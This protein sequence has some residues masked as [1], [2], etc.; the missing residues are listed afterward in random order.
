MR[1]NR[2]LYLLIVVMIVA[3]DQGSKSLA[4]LFL[5]DGKVIHLLGD[6]LI[7]LQ[8]TFNPGIAFGIRI[9][10]PIVLTVI[11]FIAAVGLSI[12]LFRHHELPLFQGTPFAFIIGGAIGN[13]ICR[14]RFGEVTDFVSVDF[15]DFIMTRWPT[16]NVADAAISVSVTYLLIM[17]LFVR[18]KYRIS[19]NAE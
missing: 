5:S 11:A 18:E 7:W 2:L 13:L 9:L 15:P 4:R 12:Y 14:I 6:D 17:S 8:L 16:F 19:E 3:L 1:N 10:S